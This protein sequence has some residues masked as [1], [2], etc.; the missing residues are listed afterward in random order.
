VRTS[1]TSSRRLC[2]SGL[3]DLL[4]E[5]RRGDLMDAGGALMGLGGR[6]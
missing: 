1:A 3:V 6:S 5:L 4:A 2:G